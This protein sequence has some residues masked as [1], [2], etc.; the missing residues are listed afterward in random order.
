MTGR[1]ARTRLLVASAV[2][3]ATLVV[4]VGCGP[5]QPGG[6]PG[7]YTGPDS[8]VGGTSCA[9]PNEGC[10]CSDPG[11]TVDCGNVVQQ[12]G[13]YV[14]CSE[15]TRTCGASGWGECVGQF[16]T[17]KALPA[18]GDLTVQGLNPSTPCMNDPCD[19]ACNTFIDNP[20]GLDAGL[21]SGLVITEAGVTLKG[22]PVSVAACT[23][24]QITPNT[25]PAKDLAVTTMAPSPN[26]VAYTATI[27]PPSCYKGTPTFLWSIDQYSIAQISSSGLLT[28]AVPIAGPITVSAYAGTLGASV[29]C[30]VTVNVV[31]TSAAPTGYTNTQFPVTTGTADNINVLYPYA[32]TVFPLGLPSPLV[33][34]SNNGVAASAVKVTLR[35][36]ATG[37]PIFSWCRSSRRHRPRRWPASRGRPS[38]SRSGRT[39]S[40]PSCTTARPERTP[41]SPSSDTSGA[42]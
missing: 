11:Q 23:S 28:L 31:D 5:S 29:V 36:P 40:R 39:S 3:V 7:S 27:L 4:L 35:Y 18:S 33:Q 30:N 41:S 14:T 6:G 21:D 10:P 38:R 15:G 17:T 25:S 16:T 1:Q 22:T 19:P 24:L 13:N 9:T 26:T 12:S 32:A 37:T 2:A 20:T 8:S 42:R 34:W